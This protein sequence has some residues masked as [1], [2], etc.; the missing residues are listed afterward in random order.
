MKT[1][2]L[3]LFSVAAGYA[4]LTSASVVGTGCGGSGS[5]G[6]G[7]ST[8]TGGA[9]AA[10]VIA[11]ENKISD[12][13]DIAAA[14]VVQSGGRNGYWYTY[15]DDNPKGTSATCVQTPPSGPQQLPDPPATYIG[16]APPSPSPGPSGGAALNGKWTG[17]T[18]WGAGIGA[19]LAQP[20]QDG[21]TYT[22]PKVPYDLTPYKGVTFWAMAVVGSDTALRIKLPMTDETKI[23]DGG[24]CMESST[25]KC[26]DDFGAK[27]NLPTNGTWKQITVRFSDATFVQEGWGAIFPWNPQHV[28]SIQ[29]QS[30]N[31]GEPYDFFIDDMYFF[32]E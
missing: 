2:L 27:F 26:S 18:I 17:C 28:T 24:L 20:L 10:P 32:T 22:G 9:A 21:G 12:F 19:D 13:E 30:Q 11:E 5:G 25:N 23:E 1:R 6:G 15:N 7:G 8:G 14:T 16:T 31:K 29:I 3:S 4:L